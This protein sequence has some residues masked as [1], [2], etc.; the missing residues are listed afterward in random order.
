MQCGAQRG[1]P[2]PTPRA[3]HPRRASPPS[4]GGFRR[5]GN[6]PALCPRAA[7]RPLEASLWLLSLILLFAT[8]NTACVFLLLS[9]P[10]VGVVEGTVDPSPKAMKSPV[11]GTCRRRS[12]VRLMRYH[13]P[14]PCGPPAPCRRSRR[15]SWLSE[16]RDY[17]CSRN[18]YCPEKRTYGRSRAVRAQPRRR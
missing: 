2:T 16:R 10:F 17:C 7:A 6:S 8:G 5:A 9:G 13:A 18:I 3:T 1:S 15:A 4:A 14:A 12:E 11:P